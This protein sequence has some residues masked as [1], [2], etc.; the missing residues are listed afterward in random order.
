LPIHIVGVLNTL[1]STSLVVQLSLQTWAS[2]NGT[3]LLS[4]TASLP[5]SLGDTS[6]SMDLVMFGTLS[7]LLEWLADFE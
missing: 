5:P 3:K 1:D 7:V 2:Y 6:T 4:M